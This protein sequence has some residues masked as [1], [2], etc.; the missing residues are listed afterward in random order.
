MKPV[1]SWLES[2]QRADNSDRRAAGSQR[3]HADRGSA[4]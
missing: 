4:L 1:R 3:S 2:N